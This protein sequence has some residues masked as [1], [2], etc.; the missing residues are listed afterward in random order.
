MEDENINE[1]KSVKI[2]NEIEKMKR[3]ISKDNKYKEAFSRNKEL[4]KNILID[5]FEDLQKAYNR[6]CEENLFKYCGLE[7]A[8]KEKIKLVDIYTG[9]ICFLSKTEDEQLNKKE[10][11]IS[12]YKIK[13]LQKY[14]SYN[15]EN[16]ITELLVDEGLWG[17]VEYDDY[18]GKY[19]LYIGKSKDIDAEYHARLNIVDFIEVFNGIRKEEARKV[20]L[21]ALDI[22]IKNI[23][24]IRNIC[25]RNI[26]IIDNEFYKYDYLNRLTSEIQETI[27]K[28][29]G[30]IR[31]E[32]YFPDV[33]D[34]K[35]YVF[36]S[37]EY[38]IEKLKMP[39]ALNKYINLFVALELIEKETRKEEKSGN[40]NKTGLYHV[41]EF[42]DDNL[43][44]ANLIAKAILE[45]GIKASSF[46]H[47]VCAEILGEEKADKIFLDKN[48]KK[49]NKRS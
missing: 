25:L 31:Y 8:E 32:V 9:Y 35:Y 26:N 49:K 5:E 43:K 39:K 15:G 47:K 24:P 37:N 1:S 13:N 3:L 40:K 2:K 7:D 23:E 36:C 28:F 12:K 46:S 6:I 19:Y 10:E 16:I 11:Y 20:I 17:W 4:F 38:V 22:K 34:D 27:K 14:I 18:S 44:N 21:N 30:F 45:K 33:I 41:K 29:I 42:N 48:L